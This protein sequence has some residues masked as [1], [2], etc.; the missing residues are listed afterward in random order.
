MYDR[1]NAALARRGF[2]N[3]PDFARRTGIPASSLYEIRDGVV[4]KPARMAAIC[5]HLRVPEPLFHYGPPED[6][7]EALAMAARRLEEFR[8]QA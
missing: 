5:H 1:L 6:F 3:I 4:P 2:K 7:A 8:S